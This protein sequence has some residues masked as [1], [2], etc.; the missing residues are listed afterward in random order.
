M[1]Q[2]VGYM[3]QGVEHK[4]RG[5]EQ[6]KVNDANFDKIR[7]KNNCKHHLRIEN[8]SVLSYGLGN[9]EGFQKININILN[10]DLCFMK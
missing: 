7:R 5:L 3:F 8:P 2:G 6:K 9:G 10:N 1:S 4:F